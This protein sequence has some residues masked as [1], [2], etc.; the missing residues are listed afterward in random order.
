LAVASAQAA[1]LDEP[2]DSA[3]VA[4]IGSGVPLASGTVVAGAAV[5]QW[6]LLGAVA[7]FVTVEIDA[8]APVHSGVARE[9]HRALLAPQIDSLGVARWVLAGGAAWVRMPMP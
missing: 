1:V 7:P 4:G 2:A 6:R 3:R 8:Q 5:A 9:L